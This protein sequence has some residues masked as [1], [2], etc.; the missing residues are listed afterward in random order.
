MVKK[1]NTWGNNAQ[2]VCD[3]TEDLKT[4]KNVHFGDSCL[5]I[6]TGVKYVLD[7][8]FWWYS[9]DG[10]TDPIACDCVE[11]MTIWGQIPEA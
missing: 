11:E 9:V 7:S 3:D 1:I 10:K 5:V 6:H 2:W 8:K 4:M